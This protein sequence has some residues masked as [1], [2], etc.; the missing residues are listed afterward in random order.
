MRRALVVLVTASIILAGCLGDGESDVF[1]GEDI[2][3]SVPADD[4]VLVDENG[5]Y[6]SLYQLQGK[7]IVIAFLFTRCPDIC[8]IVSAN[9]DFVSE[10]LGEKFDSEVAI[11]SITVD[12]WADN[13][14]VLSA[15]AEQRGL[16]W[17]HLTVSDSS[18]LT[19]L[20]DVWRNFGVGLDVYN[21]DEDSDGVVDGFDICPG[22]PEGESVDDDGCGLETQQPDGDVKVMH[23]PLTYWVDHTTGTIIVDKQMRQRVW[24]GDTDWNAELVLE[25]IYLLLEE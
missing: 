11:L 13:S 19:E 21:S 5:D 8:P 1:Y 12:P 9:L 23:H 25:D 16:N 2:D 10:E 6:Y 20:E 14:S 4:F 17:P 7:V 15:Y 24:W 22:T 18:D 3:P